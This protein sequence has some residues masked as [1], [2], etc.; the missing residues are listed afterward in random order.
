MNYLNTTAIAVF[1]FV[2]A[3]SMNT[4]NAAE[5]NINLDDNVNNPGAHIQ[6]QGTDKTAYNLDN[7]EGS[8]I[9]QDGQI[10]NLQGDIDRAN[11]AINKAQDTA[12][13]AQDGV[14]ANTQ[15]NAILNQKIDDYKADQTITDNKQN[16]LIDNTNNKADAAL[17]G[18]IT[19]GQAIIDTNTRVD[20]TDITATN[21]NNK[22]D[23][24]TQALASKVDKSIFNADQDRQDQALQDAS[25]KATQ[26]FNTGAYA[27]SLAVDA[28]T[29]AAANKAAVATVQSRQQTQEATIQNHSAQLANHESRI[30]AL[31]SQ[32][33]AKFSSLENQQN[34]D[35]KEYRAGI[36]GAASLAGLHYVDT[37]NAVAV[38]A[39][40]FKDAQG[41]AIGYRHKFAEN[42]AAT[43]STSGTSNGNEIVAASASYGW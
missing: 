36:A 16:I 40:N 4:A 19:N 8:N 15:A 2:F 33:N 13:T 21:A 17:Q 25:G 9:K 37:D 10:Y 34:E 35:R 42:V 7:I 5:V 32:N 14:N 43:L 12:N 3:G 23:A 26:A 30:T 24:N 31:E 27:Q 11:T 39:A 29:V 38:G 28:Q 20:K 18:V 6:I 1:G 41:Y 22:A